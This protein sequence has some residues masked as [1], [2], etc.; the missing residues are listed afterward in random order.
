MKQ[1]N[2]TNRKKAEGTLKR[3]KFTKCYAEHLNTLEIMF[4]HCTKQ[5]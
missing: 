3:Q 2:K 4:I 1:D 5:I